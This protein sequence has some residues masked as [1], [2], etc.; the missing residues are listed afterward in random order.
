MEGTNGAMNEVMHETYLPISADRFLKHFAPIGGG[1]GDPERFLKYY[2]NSIVGRRAFEALSRRAGALKP[3]VVA[4]GRQMEKDERFWIAAA[5][6]GV[7]YPEE[8]RVDRLTRLLRRV[9]GDTPPVDNTASWEEFL[10]GRLDL[11]FEVNTPSPQ[12]YKQWL[13]DHL[14][15]RVIV[16][17]LHEAASR[18]GLALEGA[19]K[20]DAMLISESGS[21]VVFEAKVLADASTTIR[22]DVMRNQ[23]ART[24]DVMLDPHPKLAEPLANRDPD[25]TCFVLVT[26][27]IF[28]ENPHSRLYGRLLNEY[29]TDP[30]TL[31]RDLLHRTDVD[32]QAVAER[33]GWL[34]FEDCEEISPGSCPWLGPRVEIASDWGTNF[35]SE[36]H[37]R[38]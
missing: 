37:D 16:P 38:T 3:Q 9:L 30:S 4:R 27:R 26:P 10:A 23:L 35:H 20:V 2:W 31:E 19:T 6:L 17:Y 11:Y 13:R 18:A 24:I 14:D 12:G 32:W 29:R 15:E 7:F 5:L 34:T 28:Q 33:L 21:S 8:G 36:D 25:R 1:G 22:F